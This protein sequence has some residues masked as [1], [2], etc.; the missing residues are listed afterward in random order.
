MKRWLL[1]LWLVLAGCSAKSGLE[2]LHPHRGTLEE[3]FTEEAVTR[4]VKT[5]LVRM[6]AADTLRV[7]KRPS[8]SDQKRL[9]FRLGANSRFVRRLE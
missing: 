7:I 2:T 3:S 1:I 5:W 4:P 6:P 8:S 9:V